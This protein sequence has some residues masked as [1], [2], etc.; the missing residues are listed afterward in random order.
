MRNN[1]LI[2]TALCLSGVIFTWALTEGVYGVFF[3]NDTEI[4]ITNSTSEDFSIPYTLEEAWPAQRSQSEA[5]WLSSGAYFYS[6]NGIGRTHF[7]ELESTNIWRKRYAISNPED[8]TDGKRPQ[9]IFRLV[10]KNSFTNGTQEV[11]ARIS[12]YENSTSVH[13]NESNGIHLFNRYQDQHTLYYVGLQVDGRGVIQKKLN[14][15]YSVLGVE[16]IVEGKYD[17][18][19][20]TNILPLNTWIGVKSELMTQGDGTVKIAL[21]TDIGRTGQWTKALEVTD[22]CQTNGPCIVEAGHSGIRTDF[23]DVA[24]DDYSIAHYWDYEPFHSLF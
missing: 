8:T 24:F 12:F 14:G 2:V 11:Y 19:T 13:R 21:Y 16:K 7:G 1:V 3:S 6:E 15:T 22:D 4:L 17:I 9:N 18:R 20:S 23:M 5:W 10:F